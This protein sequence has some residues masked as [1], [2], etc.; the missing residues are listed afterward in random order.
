MNKTKIC[1]VAVCD[2]MSHNDAPQ[3]CDTCDKGR[4]VQLGMASLVPR[5][6]KKVLSVAVRVDS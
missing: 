1:E 4:V 6:A 5:H 3:S 2:A